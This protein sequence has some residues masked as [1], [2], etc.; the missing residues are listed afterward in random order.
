METCVGSDLRRGDGRV[1]AI[2]APTPNVIPAQAGTYASFH[3]RNPI[4]EGTRA[5]QAPIKRE[6][7]FA[8]AP[9]FSCWRHVFD[10]TG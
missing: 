6:R 3:T 4:L 5:Q 10:M 9:T 7:E 2:G 8:W 1:E